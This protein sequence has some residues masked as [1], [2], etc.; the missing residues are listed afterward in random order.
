MCVMKARGLAANSEVSSVDRKEPEWL[1]DREVQTSKL[2][3]VYLNRHVDE[4][5]HVS[6]NLAD[7]K[8]EICVRN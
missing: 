8:I 2:Q 6:Y 4:D 3:K 5:S 7:G 1:L